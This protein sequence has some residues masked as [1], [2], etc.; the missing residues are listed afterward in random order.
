M[1]GAGV[2]T[3][4]I[5]HAEGR[6]PEP[7]ARRLARYWWDAETEPCYGD[8]TA[9]RQGEH[10]YAYGHAKGTAYVYV[11]RVHYT[12]ATELNCYE[13]W[14]GQEWQLERLYNVGEKEGFFWQIQQGQMIYSDY[15][16]CFLFVYTDNFWNSQIQ[17]VASW[18][19]TGPWTAP[20]LLYQAKPRQDGGCVYSPA[21]H[22]YYDASGKSI[23]ITF[24]NH[25]NQ[26]EAIKVVSLSRER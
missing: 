6:S 11:A 26:I 15:Y 20:V 21:V 25:P 10:I 7:Y 24:T 4:T 12:K 5:A 18:L 19:P 23:I 8:V 3:V 22:T 16:Q 17:A 14:N 2:A 9:V 1:V 13:Y